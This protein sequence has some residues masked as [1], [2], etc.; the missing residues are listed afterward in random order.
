MS[1]AGYPYDNA[2]KEVAGNTFTDYTY[3]K[4]GNQ[5]YE[6]SQ[7]GVSGNA[8]TIA[9]GSIVTSSEYDEAGNV[10]LET[11]GKGVKTKYAY[12]DENRITDI[13]LDY[14]DENTPVSLHADY[15][16]LIFIIHLDR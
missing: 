10:V 7:P 9:E 5:T 4:S 8:Y 16:I 11:D 15:S 12:D 2:P 6:I 3:D 1:K 14:E 13:Y